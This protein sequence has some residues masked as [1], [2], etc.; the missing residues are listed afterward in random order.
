VSGC[1]LQPEWLVFVRVVGE[2]SVGSEDYGAWLRTRRRM[3][4]WGVLLGCGGSCTDFSG[5]E[6]GFLGFG[7]FSMV[8]ASIVC[9]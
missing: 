4:R 2:G 6:S 1:T 7:D 5:I 8:L 9:S 3:G